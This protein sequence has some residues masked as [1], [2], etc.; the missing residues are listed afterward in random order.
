MGKNSLD[1]GKKRRGL[2]R[3]IHDFVGAYRL[4]IRKNKRTF[5]VYTILR[6]LVVVCI[7]RQFML[8]NYEAV[9]TA[10]LTL[11][12]LTLPASMELRLKVDI[13][14]TL[15]IIILIFIYSAEIMGEVN[16]YYTRIPFWDTIL[17][18]L[19]GFLAAAVGFSLVLVLNKR[20]DVIFDVSPFFVALVAFC[21]SMTIG[22]C[23]EF[24]EF[25][26]DHL[27]GLDMQKDTVIHTLSSGLLSP[28]GQTP[29]KIHHIHKV[30]VN[31]QDLG[32]GGYIDVG[33]I[34]TMEDLFVNFIGAL[35]FSIIGYYGLKGNNILSRIAGMFTLHKKTASTDYLAQ[36]RD[37]D[38][39][40]DA[41]REMDERSGEEL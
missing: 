14:Q 37:Q 9:F 36:E 25:T 7:V 33:L 31:G 19:N 39:V 8:G 11:V 21:F 41:L 18:T 13:P 40:E 15:E 23:W 3:R 12:L 34:D 10:V 4:E 6:A 2:G 16:Q 32:V 30:A 35:T 22:V 5:K 29:V 20:E 24:I 38:A 27:L 26:L 28:D 1:G 17:H